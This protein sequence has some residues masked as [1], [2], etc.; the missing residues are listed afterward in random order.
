MHGMSFSITR[1]NP[2]MGF[3]F[4]IIFDS[5]PTL[6]GRANFSRSSLN[7]STMFRHAEHNPRRLGGFRQGIPLTIMS[8][9]HSFAT[10]R[11]CAWNTIN[12]QPTDTGL[13]VSLNLVTVLLIFRSQSKL[14]NSIYSLQPC[15][16]HFTE[17]TVGNLPMARGTILDD[18]AF[19][20][21]SPGFYCIKSFRS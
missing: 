11:E 9:A 13:R 3:L 7:F 6:G 2:F 21:F 14:I 5:L 1:Q 4:L 16:V 15:N 19:L 12:H 18:H 10:D 17:P 20:Q 8:V